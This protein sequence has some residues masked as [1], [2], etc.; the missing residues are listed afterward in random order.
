MSHLNRRTSLAPKPVINRAATNANGLDAAC[1][2]LRERIEWE[3]SRNERFFGNVQVSVQ[4]IEGL[5]D[6]HHIGL[7]N[8]NKN[9]PVH[10]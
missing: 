3:L 8:S 7:D 5:V 1:Q 2:A 9:P 4:L 10:Q 6:R